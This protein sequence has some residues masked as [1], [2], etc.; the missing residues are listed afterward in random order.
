M[1]SKSIIPRPLHKGDVVGVAAVSGPVNV[2]DLEKGLEF[3]EELGF[4][5]E[6]GRSVYKQQ[7]YLAGSD[8]DR[9]DDLNKFISDSMIRGI[10]FARGGYGSMRIISDINYEAIRKDPKIM[11]GMSDLTALFM[12]TFQRCAMITLAGPMPAVQIAAGLDPTSRDFLIQSL[13]QPLEHYQLLGKFSSELKTLRK[14][15]AS[16]I[17]L[18]GCLS[19]LVSMLGTPYCPSFSDC[20]L[21]I[22]DVNEPPYRIDRMLTQLKLAGVFDQ[23]SGVVIGHFSGDDAENAYSTV[24]RV[25]IDYTEPS[26]IPVISHYPHGHALPNI[27]LPVG[28]SVKLEVSEHDTVFCLA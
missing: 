22:E 11:I 21:L 7:D 9:V 3:I 20:V 19:L 4:R 1:R 25:V 13:T 6:L 15:N 8:T 10:F 26:S 24:E 28:A 16:G 5:V 14:G 2:S 12:A 17:L 27:T 18:G 23:I